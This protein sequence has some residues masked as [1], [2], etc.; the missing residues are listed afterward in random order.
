MTTIAWD[1]KTLAADK[2]CHFGDLTISMTKIH[3]IVLKARHNPNSP[4]DEDVLIALIGETSHAQ[5]VAWAL[6]SGGPIPS[7]ADSDSSKN[8]T[9]GPCVVVIFQ[10]G[11]VAEISEMGKW[12]VF[13][14]LATFARGK[15]EDF[16]S[17]A[18]EAG[19]SAVGAVALAMKRGLAGEGISWASFKYPVTEWNFH[20][21]GSPLPERLFVRDNRG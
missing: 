10:D 11:N 1:G 7:F 8:T 16:V 15:G 21:C 13:G 5:E 12:A 20:P 19:V 17:G 18:L 3:R 9:I 4:R 2:A 14:T 6:S